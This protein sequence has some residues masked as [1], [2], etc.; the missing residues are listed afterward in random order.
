MS[1]R[2]YSH[3][4]GPG[5]CDMSPAPPSHV[6]G[7]GSIHILNIVKSAVPGKVCLTIDQC[8][9]LDIR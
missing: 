2:F 5:K 4:C 7:G 9:S 8:L 3:L 1:L 6:L